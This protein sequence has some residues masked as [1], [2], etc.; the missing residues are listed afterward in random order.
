MTSKEIICK[1]IDERLINGEEAYTLLND[2]LKGEIV[3]C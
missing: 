1:L 2:V 3:N